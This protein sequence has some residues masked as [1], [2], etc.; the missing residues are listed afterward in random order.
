M[1]GAEGHTGIAGM[2]PSSWGVR[3][4]LA[5]NERQHDKGS[6]WQHHPTI[7][8]HLAGHAGCLLLVAAIIDTRKNLYLTGTDGAGSNMLST[9][10]LSFFV[11]NLIARIWYEQ[12]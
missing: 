6:E 8:R 7:T 1:F 12:I 3:W 5:I 11:T 2:S 9:G 10:A 4:R